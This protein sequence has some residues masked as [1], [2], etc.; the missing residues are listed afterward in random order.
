MHR[1]LSN[2]FCSAIIW[3]KASISHLKWSWTFRSMC[4]V[5]RYLELGRLSQNL[6]IIR[7]SLNF[8]DS[9]MGK[10]VTYCARSDELGGGGGG[11]HDYF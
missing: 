9:K 10:M 2:E 5:E 8:P 7:F 1:S 6:N 4:F 11:G 3:Q